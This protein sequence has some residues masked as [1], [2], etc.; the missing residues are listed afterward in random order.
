LDTTSCRSSRPYSSIFFLNINKTFSNK[1]DAVI[2]Q[3]ELHFL[4]HMREGDA[5][6]F[7]G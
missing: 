6:F 4:V 7:Y 2:K 1:C 3:S 5:A